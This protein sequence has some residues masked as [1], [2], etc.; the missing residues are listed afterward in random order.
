MFQYI[1]KICL[2]DM[3]TTVAGTAAP[4]T[5]TRGTGMGAMVTR[6]RASPGDSTR[7]ILG[8]NVQFI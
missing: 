1:F 2:V 4:G 5:T 7:S 3:K 6:T 8:E